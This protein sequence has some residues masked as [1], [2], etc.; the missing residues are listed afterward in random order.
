[1]NCVYIYVSIHIHIPVLE[2]RGD[3]MVFKYIKHFCKQGLFCIF[4]VTAG[5]CNGRTL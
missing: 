2:R 1:M 4:F 3:N 5:G